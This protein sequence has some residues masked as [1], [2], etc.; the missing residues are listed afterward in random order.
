MA[1]KPKILVI[2]DDGLLLK[3]LSDMLDKKGYDVDTAGDGETG[4]KLALDKKPALIIL[5]YQMPGMDGLTMLQQLRQ[6][7]S[8]QSIEV[9]FA[10]NTYDT[11]V[12]NTALS[13]GVHDYI[14]KSDSSLEQIAELVNQYVPPSP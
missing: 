9:I 4:L 8:T 6:S 12:I 2:D 10:T 13:L 11:S 3:S 1:E 7:D 5:D 14:L